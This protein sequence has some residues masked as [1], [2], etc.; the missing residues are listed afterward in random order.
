MLDITQ[1]QEIVKQRYPF[2]FIDRVLELEEGLSAKGIKCVTINE[3]FFTGHFPGHPLMP[4]V[5]ILEAM[6]Q[7]SA[8]AMGRKEGSIGLLASVYNARFLHPV[9]PGDQLVLETRLSQKVKNLVCFKASAKVGDK[10]VAKAELGF[11]ILG[12]E[13]L[14]NKRGI[15]DN[16]R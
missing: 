9:S 15:T 11:I 8:V 4:G 2:L 16:H 1:I 3:G 5:L 10:I 14:M 13:E 6:A 7:L 12:K